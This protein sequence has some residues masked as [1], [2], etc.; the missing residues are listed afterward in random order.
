MNTRKIHAQRLYNDIFLNLRREASENNRD[1]SL[2]L[3]RL[4]PSGLMPF[5]CRQKVI[6]ILPPIPQR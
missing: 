6:V 3:S 1:L 4:I 5:I 2:V